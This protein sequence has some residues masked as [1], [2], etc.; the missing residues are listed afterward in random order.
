MS[1]IKTKKSCQEQVVKIGLFLLVFTNSGC[2]AWSWKG[3]SQ[4]GER[5]TRVI[6]AEN[7]RLKDLVVQLRSSNEDMAQRA[8]DDSARIAKLEEENQTLTTSVAAYQS[9]RERMA[10]AFQ[11]LQQQ[12]QVALSD[13]GVV[14]ASA[15]QVV[16]PAGKAKSDDSTRAE[17]PP[18]GRWDADKHLLVLD[19]ETWFAGD[20]AILSQEKE[21]RLARL[22]AWMSSRV[23]GQPTGQTVVTRFIGPKQDPLTR[24]SL[25]ATP[26]VPSPVDDSTGSGRFDLDQARSKRLWEALCMKIR[27]DLAAQIRFDG[28]SKPDVPLSERA[29][30]PSL[31]IQF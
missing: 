31:V 11:N 30:R 19:L 2:S 25:A 17:P 10:K 29:G 28:K 8:L 21:M 24:V 3:G 7:A 14:S 12:V 18:E 23:A 5:L 20:S 15:T 27:P 1:G 9:E 26:P 22:A 6:H 4:D 16:E 13:R